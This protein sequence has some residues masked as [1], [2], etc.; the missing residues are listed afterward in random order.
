M[1]CNRKGTVH[2]SFSS[3]NRLLQGIRSD[4]KLELE[5]SALGGAIV[6]RDDTKIRLCWGPSAHE[7]RCAACHL[8]R[9]CNFHALGYFSYATIP[10]EMKY[11]S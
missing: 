2:S 6:L 10:E 1:F 11:Y 3:A 5:I 8:P 7:N 4:E 9:G